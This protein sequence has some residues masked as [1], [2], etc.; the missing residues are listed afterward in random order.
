MS[1][2]LAQSVEQRTENPC[3]AGSIP[4]GT[5]IQKPR[6]FEAFFIPTIF[7]GS[8]YFY[9]MGKVW[10][11]FIFAI[12]ICGKVSKGQNFLA[13]QLK[14]K[15]FNVAYQNRD[16]AINKML[17]ANKLQKNNLQILIRAFKV[18]KSLEIWAKNKT[19]KQFQLLKT[20]AICALSGDL[21]PKSK[22]GD[23]QIPEGIYKI[24]RFNPSSAFHLSLGINYPNAADLKRNNLNPGGDIFIHGDCV[25]IGCLPMTNVYM[26][27][28]Y[29]LAV[30]A[31]SAGQKN[32]NVFILPSK[33]QLNTTTIYTEFWKKLL[34]TNDYFEQNKV[35][36]SYSIN[37]LGHY[38]LKK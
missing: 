16:N 10:I 36:P 33:K 3:V 19:S 37:A 12:C 38:E 14:V 23:G 32:I 8:F 9:G 18:E 17:E 2:A 21:G 6:I 11:L 25:T 13:Q 35:M 5:T 1:G 31:K 4:A 28:I 22:Q 24:D 20:Y 7:T 26:E 15:R 34:V 27:E 30:L 29:A